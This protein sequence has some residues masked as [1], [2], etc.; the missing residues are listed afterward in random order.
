M[1]VHLRL[2]NL[3]RRFAPDVE[4]TAFRV[5]Q[6]ALT[7]VARHAQVDFATVQ[8]HADDGVLTL[9]VRDAGRGFDLAQPGHS[10]GLSGMRERVHLLGGTIDI[11]AM[12]GGGTVVTAELPL[13]GDGPTARRQDDKAVS[14]P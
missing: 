6:E 5:V 13:N 10:S 1:S 3:A 7:N 9:V 12:P 8:L 4:I 14:R 11:D 2:G